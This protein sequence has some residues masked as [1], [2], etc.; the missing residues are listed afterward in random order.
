MHDMLEAVAPT[1]RPVLLSGESG[2]GK[3]VFAAELHARSNRGGRPFV[4]VDCAAV[5]EPGYEAELFGHVKGA[6][7]GASRARVGAFEAAHGGTLFFDEIGE[8]PLAMQAKL[9]AVIERREIVRLG[10]ERPVAVDV[11]IVSST[12]RDLVA[13]CHSGAFRADLLTRL[14]GITLAI[15]PLRT[16]LGDIAPLAA[17]FLRL[18]V[19]RNGRHDVTLTHEALRALESYDWPGNVR[20]LRTVIERAVMHASGATLTSADLG[21]GERH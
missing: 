16:R 11:R 8:L 6:F 21:L 14:G 7:P 19:A 12:T 4:A 2:V 3:E 1:D 17:H 15:P 18:A 20:E 10:E 13:S 9:L 5:A